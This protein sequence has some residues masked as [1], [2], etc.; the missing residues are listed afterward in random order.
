MKILSSFTHSQ[1][2]QTC[3]NVFVMLN[4]NEDMLKKQSSSGAPLTSIVL[5]FPMEVNGA[6]R[7]PGYKRSS[8][9]LCLTE[10]R[11]SYR[12]GTTWEWVNDDRIFIFGWT[13]PLIFLILT[14]FFCLSFKT[15]VIVCRCCQKRNRE[16]FALCKLKNVNVQ[17]SKKIGRQAL[18]RFFRLFK[19]YGQ[20]QKVKSDIMLTHIHNILHLQA[21][22]YSG[23]WG[24]CS[25][26]GVPLGLPRY[27][28]SKDPLF[29]GMSSDTDLI[30]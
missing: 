7:Q 18:S 1:V 25:C 9:Y 23:N 5:F 16:H 20:T 15:L 11:N 10:Q 26:G 19:D 4:T 17:K 13:F 21:S 14:I 24:G 27:S 8:K 3:M 6:P 12:V 28:P 30:G 2:F 22:G 29:Y